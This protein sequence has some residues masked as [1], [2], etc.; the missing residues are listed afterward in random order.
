[1]IIIISGYYEQCVIVTHASI[2]ISRNRGKNTFLQTKVAAAP[3]PASTASLGKLLLNLLRAFTLTFFIPSQTD[4]SVMNSGD[5]LTTD[6]VN[7]FNDSTSST[8]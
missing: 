5:F 6:S 3:T 2:R 4:S 1:M 7:F 8:S